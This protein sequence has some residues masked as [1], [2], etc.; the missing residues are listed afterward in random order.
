MRPGVIRW[1]DG[2]A[3]AGGSIQSDFVPELDDVDLVTD[4]IINITLEDLP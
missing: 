3:I 4:T 2:R 1:V